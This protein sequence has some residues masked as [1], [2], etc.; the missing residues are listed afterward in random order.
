MNSANTN[1][2]KRKEVLVVGPWA[3]T[4]GV[5]TF[6]RNL[7]IHSNLNETWRFERYNIARPPK[8]TI[9]NNQYNFLTSDPKRLL[10]SVYVTGRNFLKFPR[11]VLQADIV[12][13]QASDHYAFWEPL[14]YARV[15]KSLGTPAVVRFGGSFDNFYESSTPNQQKMMIQALQ[16]PDALVVLSH[17][18][19]DY[20]GKYVDREKIHVIP[21]AVP[22]PPPMPDRSKREGKPTILWISGMEAKRK[23]IDAMLQLVEKLHDKAHFLFVAVTEQLQETIEQTGL[24]K[25]IEMHG[26]Q[27]REKMNQY[28]YPRADIFMLPSFG[29][30]FPNSMLEAMAAGLPTIT[31]PVGAI[32]E[33]LV[34]NEHGFIN[35]PTD[36]DGMHRDLTYLLDNQKERLRMGKNSYDLV[37]STYSLNAV[38]TRYDQLWNSKIQ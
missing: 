5:H 30:G 27:H 24:D 25:Y 23:G 36:V 29:E 13:L 12:Q 21:N 11:A 2:L 26:I 8:S 10:K 38:F 6:M 17:G 33:V 9:D 20:F 14:A 31:T 34:P 32:P 15:V 28:F 37:C 1:N 16:I 19:K 4:G 7:G 22:V 3:S 18:W 35:D